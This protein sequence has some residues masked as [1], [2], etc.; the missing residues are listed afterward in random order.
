MT[1]STVTTSAR[2]P[3]EVAYGPIEAPLPVLAMRT[4]ICVAVEAKTGLL[5]EVATKAAKVTN[6]EVL[7][8]TLCATAMRI[9]I[10]VAAAGEW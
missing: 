1:A 4:A 6:A 9:M 2:T 5:L 7:P 10:A 8:G 3:V